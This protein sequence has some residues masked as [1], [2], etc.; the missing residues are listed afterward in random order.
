[1][2]LLHYLAVG[3]LLKGE[4][5]FV[6]GGHVVICSASADDR[7]SSIEDYQTQVMQIMNKGASK[8]KEDKRLRLNADDN[9]Y[10]LHVVANGRLGEDCMLVYFA[11]TETTF[12]KTSVKE[13][14]NDFKEGILS[15][16]SKNEIVK[17]KAKG[18]IHQKAQPVLKGI[19]KKYGT[20]KLQM[21]SGQVEQVKGIMQ[22]NV[23]KALNNVDNLNELENKSAKFEEQ[24]KRF[25]KQSGQVKKMMRCQ[26]YKT[27]IIMVLIAVG[28][29]LLL[30][31]VICAS[32]GCKKNN[33][34]DSSE[35]SD[36]SGRR[37]LMMMME[38][39]GESMADSFM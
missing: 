31:G 25:E 19:L 17:A 9:K 38:S 3:R 37:L 5:N 12:A 32:V 14:L 33:K 30:T 2:S 20:D 26:Y 6:E 10:D 24:A 13:M 8:L 4:G 29:I 27:I 16:A 35:S 39:A 36:A 34:V 22:D 15:T 11:V 1:M 18:S 21:V 28:L 7:S 23:S